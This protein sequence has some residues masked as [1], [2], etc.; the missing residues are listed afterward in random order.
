MARA[1]VLSDHA[2]R[3]LGH[4]VGNKVQQT[5]ER[6]RYQAEMD[7]A[8][9]KLADLIDNIVNPPRPQLRVVAS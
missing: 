5:Y 2:E 7:A 8:L 4:T 6:Y 3:V 9:V 1:G